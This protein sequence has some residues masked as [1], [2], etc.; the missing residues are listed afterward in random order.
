MSRVPTHRS[1]CWLC[2]SS[3]LR[4]WS[5]VVYFSQLFGQDVARQVC[6]DCHREL[7]RLMKEMR[8]VKP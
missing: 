3:V 8:G 5:R 2:S 4:R 1:R 7:M 6:W